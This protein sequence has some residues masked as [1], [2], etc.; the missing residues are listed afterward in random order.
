MRALADKESVKSMVVEGY[1]A[2]STPPGRQLLSSGALKALQTYKGFY[3]NDTFGG[4]SGAGVFVEG[5]PAELV[6]VHTNGV[7]GSDPPWSKYNAFT[8]M[9]AERLSRVQEWIG[10]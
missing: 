2:N 5:S 3:D 6:G 10:Q 8:R 7:Y 4:T 9:T 1:A